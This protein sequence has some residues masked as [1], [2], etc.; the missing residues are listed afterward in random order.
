[1]GRVRFRSQNSRFCPA[2]PRGPA[3]IPAIHSQPP[4]PP[5]PGQPSTPPSKIIPPCPTAPNVPEMLCPARPVGTGDRSAMVGDHPCARAMPPPSSGLSASLPD[6]SS[7]RPHSAH[8]LPIP[9]VAPGFSPKPPPPPLIKTHCT[10]KSPLPPNTCVPT[11]HTRQS[12][13]SPIA[14]VRRSPGRDEL[15]VVGVVADA[16]E[17]VL[18]GELRHRRQHPSR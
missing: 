16:V 1:M 11:H 5:P 4:P 6:H 10:P 3:A 12:R 14:P 17:V 15:L 9:F 18:P 13:T 2:A 8:N 7:R